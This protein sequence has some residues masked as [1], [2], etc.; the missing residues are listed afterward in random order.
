MFDPDGPLSGC[1]YYLHEASMNVPP[2]ASLILAKSQNSKRDSCAGFIF[3]K[4]EKMAAY[5]CD[6]RDAIKAP[7][8][9]QDWPVSMLACFQSLAMILL[10]RRGLQT[11]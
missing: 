8:S 3:K 2:F 11:F 10:N 9:A 7:I 4:V 5:I 6:V 1:L